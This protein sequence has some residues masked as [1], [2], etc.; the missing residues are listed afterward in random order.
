ML[1]QI[2]TTERQVALLAACPRPRALAFVPASSVITTS[3]IANPA[4]THRVNTNPV[5]TNS[6]SMNPVSI[7]AVSANPVTTTVSAVSVPSA[8]SHL[9]PISAAA[10]ARV[11]G[12]GV[13]AGYAVF[14][15]RPMAGVRMDAAVQRDG[16]GAF[17]LNL[18]LG[19]DRENG[20]TSSK[21]QDRKHLT[22]R[23]GPV[24]WRPPH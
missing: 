8:W 15:P 1:T 22:A 6:V 14:V 16:E 18:G 5:N 3:V 4:P 21:Q 7:N 10:F 13:M 20:T 19:L 9:A 24:T 17:G 11:P 12:F 23:R 2:Q